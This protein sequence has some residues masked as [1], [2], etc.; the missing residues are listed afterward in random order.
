MKSKGSNN[1]QQKAFQ[2]ELN[3][4]LEK[5]SIKKMSEGCACEKIWRW[6][7]AD[8]GRDRCVKYP[9]FPEAADNGLCDCLAFQPEVSHATGF[10]GVHQQG[11]TQP[12]WTVQPEKAC[13][14]V[15]GCKQCFRDRDVADRNRRFQKC[16]GLKGKTRSR[17]TD[18]HTGAFQGSVMR[19][20]WPFMPLLT[21]CTDLCL[22]MRQ[23]KRLT[24]WLLHFSYVS[25]QGFST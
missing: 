5:D 3:L 19:A 21:V 16:R 23:M 8:F 1:C 13:V 4:P 6:R 2:A 14:L 24:V 17:H 10:R 7:G 25:Q 12:V 18:M 22:V 15:W 11:G 20:A 9:S